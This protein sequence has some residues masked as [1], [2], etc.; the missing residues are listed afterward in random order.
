M[1]FSIAALAFLLIFGCIICGLPICCV[2]HL[3]QQKQE[4]VPRREKEIQTEPA[5]NRGPARWKRFLLGSL[6]NDHFS[7]GS[8]RIRFPVFFQHVQ[9]SWSLGPGAPRRNGFPT[10]KT[11]LMLMF[12][13]FCENG[14][15]TPGQTR[16]QK[17][18]YHD[19]K[20]E[21][22]IWK[23]YLILKNGWILQLQPC[24]SRVGYMTLFKSPNVHKSKTCQR[25]DS[26]NVPQIRCCRGDH[27]VKSHPPTFH[28]AWGYPKYKQQET[29]SFNIMKNTIHLR[30]TGRKSSW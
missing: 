21:L 16:P 30:P 5:R 25:N 24:Q 3:G 1:N 20:K 9:P 7:Q 26:K 28:A 12:L 10:P 8:G 17:K 18:N 4:T 27:H 11:E 6:F 14:K 23:M 19:K 22:I 13:E 29:Q 15:E 2:R